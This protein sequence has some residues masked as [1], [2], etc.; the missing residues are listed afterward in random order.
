MFNSTRQTQIF[1]LKISAGFTL[2]EILLVIAIALTV[3]FFS[4]AFPLRL[5]S[6]MSVR[7]A[8]E[9]LRSE[10]EKAQVYAIAGRGY[11]PWG[12]YYADS[13]ITL[14]KGDSYSA[15]DQIFDE[16]TA[17]NE[18][19]SISGFTQAVFTIPSGKP[20]TAISEITISRPGAESAS[21]SLNAEG[22]LE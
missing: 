17:I 9:E 7:D 11:S 1:S 10:L 4:A 8:R 19:V 20:E 13:V 12:V 16:E 2:I 22:A 15:R 21:F 6:Q 18:K 5:I 14:F 3:G